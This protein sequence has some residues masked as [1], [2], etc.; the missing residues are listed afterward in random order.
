MRVQLNLGRIARSWLAMGVAGLVAIWSGAG[1]AQ[2]LPQHAKDT[3]LGVVTCAGSTCHGALEPWQQ[4]NVLQNEYITWQR[5]DQHAKAYAT[6]LKDESKRIARNLKLERPAHESKLCLDC[7]SDNAPA[8]LRGARF[9]LS[10]GVG[11]EACHGGSVRY[12]G[13]HATGIATHAENVQNGLYP[14]AEPVA[15]AQLCLSC[16]FGS[17]G[18]ESKF[19]THRIMGAGHPRMSFELDTFTAIQPAHYRIDADYRKRKPVYSGVQV[20]AIGQAIAVSQS[21]TAL[22][23][24]KFGRD[25]IFPELVLFDCHA[26]H[27]PMSDVRWQPRASTGLPPGVPRLGDANLLMLV[28]AAKQVAP[29][30][31]TALSGQ[32]RGLH[33]A[34]VQ[35]P[36]ALASAARGV[37][38]SADRLVAAFAKHAFGKPDLM[39]L[40]NGVLST[41]L[42]GEFMDYAGAEQATMALAS[43][44]NALKDTGAIDEAQRKALDVAMN[45]AY[46]SVAKDEQYKPAAFVEAM[47]QVQAAA[48]KS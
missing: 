24:A 42:G 31:S 15:R 17:F 1:A 20:W 40:M 33:A 22:M 39:A 4:S 48:P 45:R 25:G 37:K 9:Q 44:V 21:M 41:G 11:C 27:H 34:A 2:T 26:C 14:T 5:Q 29:D 46:E 12:L 47:K 7:H 43:I 13:L 28:I 6:L 36:D 30:V 35:G 19:V 10:D 8:N 16:H 32:L 38:E 18:E 3:H 23:S